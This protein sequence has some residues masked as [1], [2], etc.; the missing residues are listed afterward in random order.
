MK[1]KINKFSNKIFNSK[2][3]DGIM[4]E[5]WKKTEVYR[6]YQLQ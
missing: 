2:V 1:Y 5:I 3:Y 4:G 6:K